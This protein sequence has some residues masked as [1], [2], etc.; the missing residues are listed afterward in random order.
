MD[1][2]ALTGDE[3]LELNRAVQ[4]VR[5]MADGAC[6]LAAGALDTSRA[7]EPDGARSPA[8]WMAWQ[9]RVLRSRASAALTLARRLR[10]MPRVE[11]ALLA[12]ELTTD[13]VRLLGEVMKLAPEAF[14]A[15]EERLVGL[16]AALRFP[17]FEKRLRYW[18][19]I[20][21]PDAIEDEAASAFERRELHAST[22]F[23]GTVVVNALLDPIG[24]AIVLRELERLEQQLFEADWAEARARLGDAA[25]A[26]DLLRTPKQRRADAVGVMA[27]RSAAKPAGAT[28]PRVLLQ[29]L[30]GEESLRRL[31]ELSNGRVITPGQLVPLLA[32]AD[33]QRIVFDGPSRVIDVGVR[34]RLYTGAKRIALEVR[35]RECTHPSC[36]VPAERC[37]IDHI[38]PY[39]DGGDTTQTNGHCHCGFHNRRKGRQ[40]PPAA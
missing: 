10:G 12:G 32:W 19:Q 22:T 5:S 1:L 33:V 24:G 37:E 25:C 34:Q 39:A 14:A 29:A 36:D 26:A 27:E 4:R 23:E 11:A 16:A 13:H 15:E 21:A 6:V 2:T 18:L 9:C 35:D 3:V 38:I 31:C 28:E 8:D 7:W 40:R 20:H 30:V 17:S